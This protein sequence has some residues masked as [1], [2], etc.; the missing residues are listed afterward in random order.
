ML[1]P[2]VTETDVRYKLGLRESNLGVY[3]ESFTDV[4][5]ITERRKARRGKQESETRA[6]REALQACNSSNT[7]KV[8]NTSGHYIQPS[9]SSSYEDDH[10]P[11][12]GFIKRDKIESQREI[13]LRD[14]SRS[15][16]K[17][18]ILIVSLILLLSFSPRFFQFLRPKTL[19]LSLDITLLPSSSKI[20][21]FIHSV[22]RVRL[23][24]VT[25]DDLFPK[26]REEGTGIWYA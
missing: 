17:N 5:N 20:L 4:K 13:E 9:S 23:F 16:K 6:K 15:T 25:M 26:L 14:S 3:P 21:P 1:F 8:G 7:G 22:N 12:L 2:L 19:S 10:E 11:T 24:A 18:C